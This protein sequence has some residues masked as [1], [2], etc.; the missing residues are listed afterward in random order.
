MYSEKELLQNLKNFEKKYGRVPSYRDRGKLNADTPT[1]ARRFGTWNK[2]LKA[3]GLTPTQTKRPSKQVICKNCKK[4]FK[5]FANQCAKTK[6]HF[7]SRSCAVAYNNKH[8]THGTRRSKFE[9]WVEKQLTELFP[10][11][12]ILYNDKTTSDSELDA[13]IPELRLA[14]EFNGIFHYEPIYGDEKLTKIRRNDGQKFL[15]C[16]EQ[17]IELCVIDTSQLK[18]MIPRN[19]QKYLDIIVKILASRGVKSGQIKD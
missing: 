4:Q 15:A 18:Y 8:K 2:A 1:Y 12:E 9:A 16:F 19:A 6:N 10:G 3:A 14:F 5:K 17:G 13:Y 7:C 11:L